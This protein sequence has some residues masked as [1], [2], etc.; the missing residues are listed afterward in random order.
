MSTED[1]QNTEPITEE[2][3][4]EEPK[5]E[6]AKPKELTRGEIVKARVN[7]IFSKENPDITNPDMIKQIKKRMQSEFNLTGG[8]GSKVTKIIRTVM[9]E[10][11]IQTTATPKGVT[12]KLTAANNDTEKAPTPQPQGDARGSPADATTGERASPQM[13]TEAMEKI[14]NS[15]TG[16]VTSIYV[17]LGIIHGTEVEEKPKPK[18]K[19]EE[20]K[21]VTE[22]A[23]R[24]SRELAEICTAYGWSLPKVMRLILCIG[25][26]GILYG[27]PVATHYFN[28]NKAADRAEVTLKKMPDDTEEIQKLLEAQNQ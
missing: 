12:V 15:M 24:L 20:I 6:E 27:V 3:K 14:F 11:G 8:W 5:N 28:G 10:R 13:E 18:T 9:E 4:T 19:D 1:Q 7:D 23:K 2:A 22:E 21:E 16:M 26:F 25:G 17:K